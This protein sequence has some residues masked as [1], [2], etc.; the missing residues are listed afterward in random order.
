MSLLLLVKQKWNPGLRFQ[1]S[2]IFLR[3]FVR[4][5]WYSNFWVDRRF[6]ARAHK[7]YYIWLRTDFL[8]IPTSFFIWKHHNRIYMLFCSV[9]DIKEFARKRILWFE[10]QCEFASHNLYAAVNTF[11]GKYNLHTNCISGFILC[12]LYSSDHYAFCSL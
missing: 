1:D 6:Q 9:T 8:T 5:I 7:L 12:T 2:T 11:T 4:K 10:K 3:F